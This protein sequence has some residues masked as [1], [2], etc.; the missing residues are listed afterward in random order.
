M[1]I[2]VLMLSADIVR[3]ESRI[4]KEVEKKIQ[5]EEET[6]ENEKWYKKVQ[7]FI[8]KHKV[9]FIIGGTILVVAVGSTTYIIIKKRR[10][11]II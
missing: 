7:N 10:R 2:S 8:V 3:K 6:K 5:K 11:S 1:K 4:Y 9:P